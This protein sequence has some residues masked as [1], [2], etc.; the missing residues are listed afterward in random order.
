MKKKKKMCLPNEKTGLK[1]MSVV[2][3]KNHPVYHTFF[4]AELSGDS[5]VHPNE[6]SN[7]IT[8]N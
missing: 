3:S 5:R 2:R 4:I 8:K 6:K 7:T 1:K